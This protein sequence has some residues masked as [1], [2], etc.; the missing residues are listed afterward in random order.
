MGES[1]CLSNDNE[2]IKV[3]R[4]SNVIGNDFNS[5]NFFYSILDQ[6]INDSKIE[7][8]QS[9]ESSKDYI[10]IS[11]VLTLMYKISK[12]GKE[13]IYNLAS[14][15]NVA[16]KELIDLLSRKIKFNLTF[17][18]PINNLVFN[19]IETQKIN[20]EFGFKPEP[21]IRTLDKL[22]TKRLDQK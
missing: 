17:R 14:G 18:Q 11:D 20:H 19:K 21:I 2:N 6:A 10:H 8:R 3:V 5:G 16:N 12:N 13:R 1:I 15:Y 4:L 22:I 7:L 9:L